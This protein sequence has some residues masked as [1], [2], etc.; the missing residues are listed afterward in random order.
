M[1]N[2]GGGGNGFRPLPRPCITL[3]SSDSGE[4]SC[5][6]V[7]KRKAP[8]EAVRVVRATA[9]DARSR[10][11]AQARTEAEA[12][13]VRAAEEEA[14]AT[15]VRDDVS[16]TKCREDRALLDPGKTANPRELALLAAFHAAADERAARARAAA[17]DAARA[18]AEADARADTERGKLS[19]ARASLDVVEKH[20]AQARARA[21]REAQERSDEAAEDAFAA[22]FRRS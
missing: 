20:Q 22:R 14:R 6:T 7:T 3:A 5:D 18:A 2:P 9:V 13:A 16:R 19:Q 11:L 1:P 8:L 15:S 12:L 4:R 17:D 21:E 10:D